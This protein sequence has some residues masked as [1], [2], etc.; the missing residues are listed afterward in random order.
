MKS[1]ILILILFAVYILCGCASIGPKTK[2]GAV[3]GGI[4]GAV[5]GGIVGHQSGHGL[6]GAGIGAVVGAVG[7]GLVG[8]SMDIK[9]KEAAAVN[10]DHL[11]L[12]KIAEM[13]SQGTPDAVI[14]SEIDRTHSI[15]TLN[16]EIISYLKENKVSDQV[17]DHMMETRK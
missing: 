4:V 5:A 15:Y 10:P 3:A 9:D 2:T 12:T 13:A 16:S 1:K 14:I 8:S 7:G 6:E 11:P 17:I